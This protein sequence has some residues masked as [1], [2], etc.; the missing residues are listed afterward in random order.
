MRYLVPSLLCVM[1]A[2]AAL[3]DRRAL[4]RSKK[5]ETSTPWYDLWVDFENGA[6]GNQIDRF[7]VTN[8]IRTG[9]ASVLV[10]S[11]N[12]TIGSNR[13]I[14]VSTT[15][16][17]SG[18]RSLRYDSFQDQGWIEL[19]FPGDFTNMCGGFY[20]M[21][22]A[23]FSGGTFSSY[24]WGDVKA[25]SGEFLVAPNYDDSAGNITYNVHTG[26]GIGAERPI[27]T[28]VWYWIAW[29][30]DKVNLLATM[31]IN[32]NVNGPLT[33]VGTSTLALASEN[34]GLRR[35]GR[36][37]NH[38]VNNSG[39]FAWFDDD[40]IDTNGSSWAFPNGTIPP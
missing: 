21:L 28:N 32:S 33:A 29:R 37:D 12:A 38:N 24:D 31:V 4:L 11:N 6:D 5:P 26:A 39:A 7:M 22:S 10:Y 40:C 14:T 8:M 34:A 19:D 13:L 18:T 27:F 30:W 3:G 2:L 36:I 20:L 25:T 35:I 9:V 1:L 23:G 15:Q 16:A 17:R